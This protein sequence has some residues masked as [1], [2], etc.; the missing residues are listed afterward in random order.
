VRQ[1]HPFCILAALLV[2]S[3]GGGSSSPGAGV[4]SA[5]GLGLP[6]RAWSWIDVPGAICN[7]G[8][9]TGLA[10]NPGP[11][12]T[13]VL[14][15]NGG[16]ACWD[17]ITCRTGLAEGGPYGQ[18][19]FQSDLARLGPGTIIDR[20]VV[21]GVFGAGATLVFISYCTGDVHWGD[22][23][24]DYPDVGVWH[25]AGQANLT[26]DI[27]WLA[28]RIAAP[29]RLVVSGSSAGGYGSLLA[30]HLA[31]SAWPSARGYL[32]DDAGPP[33]VGDDIPTAERTAW[34]LS[35]RLD[36]TLAPLCPGCKD[37]LSQ[38]LPSLAAR[39]P[40]DRMALISSRQDPVIGAFVL[41]T[42]ADFERALLQL[43]DQRVAPLANGRV[44]LVSGSDHAL[45]RKPGTYSAGGVSL[46]AWLA[47]M[48]NDEPA[49]STAGR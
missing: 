42:P 7:D 4:G 28:A 48:V 47:Q 34:T 43:V 18:A 29:R 33:L 2:A 37:D 44:F 1:T 45:L 16:G 31:R 40:E 12:D 24:V 6:E 46:P 9:P 30:H 38:V 26:A 5:P 19:Q 36:L 3:C 17:P 8:S 25:H 41:Q 20:A 32:I 35:W 10:V 49:W 11:G 14:F 27:G 23:T 21:D 13:L 22:G 39:Y 15:L